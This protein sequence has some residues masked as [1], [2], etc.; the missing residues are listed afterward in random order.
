[1]IADL[2][3]DLQDRFAGQCWTNISER[4]VKTTKINLRSPGA[5]F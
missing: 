4:P 3:P 5:E 1:M 2:K